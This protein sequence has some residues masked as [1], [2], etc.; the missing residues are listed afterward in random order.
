VR[1]RTSVNIDTELVERAA[2][3]LGTRGLTATVNAAMEDVVERD[4]LQRRLAARDFADLTPERLAEMRT[5][6][7][8]DWPH[9]AD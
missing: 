8:R 6:R 7:F 9:E 5:S 4:M 3:I 2:Q 1:K